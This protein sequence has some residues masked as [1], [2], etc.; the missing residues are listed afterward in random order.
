MCEILI[1]GFSAF[2][3]TVQEKKNTHECLLGKT[4]ETVALL[5]YFDSRIMNTFI[6]VIVMQLCVDFLDMSSERIVFLFC[7]IIL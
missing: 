3:H 7:I 5:L 4:A 2:C 6:E 1:F